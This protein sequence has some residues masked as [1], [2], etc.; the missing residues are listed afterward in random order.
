M[1]ELLNL[2]VL[3]VSGVTSVTVIPIFGFTKSLVFTIVI[4]VAPNPFA[5]KS[6]TVVS[7]VPAIP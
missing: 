6:E 2:C 5:V 3:V 4:V 7:T 1:F